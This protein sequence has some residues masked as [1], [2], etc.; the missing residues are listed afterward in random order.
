LFLVEEVAIDP[1]AAAKFLTPAIRPALED[2]AT[3]LTGLAEWTE[4]HVQ[5]AFESVLAERALTLGKLAQ[6]ARVALTGRTAS[7]GI[8][9]MI[10]L[11]SRERTVRRLRAALERTPAP[12]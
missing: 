2:L 1:E 7:P 11:M 5:S 6:P 10:A 12:A 8:F 4:Q 9:E 3:R